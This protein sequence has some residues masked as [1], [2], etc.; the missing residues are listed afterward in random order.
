MEL[1]LTKEQFKAVKSAELAIKKAN[2]LGVAFWD[3]Y[4]T[5]TAFNRNKITCPVPDS[6]YEFSLYEHSDIVYGL[7]L[8]DGFQ[9]GNADDPLYFNS[10]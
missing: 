3:D 4:G 1:G 2:K 10:L 9:A 8:A 7:K 6:S 5:M